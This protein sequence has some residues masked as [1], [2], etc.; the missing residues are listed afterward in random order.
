VRRAFPVREE[1]VEL[2]AVEAEAPFGLIADLPGSLQQMV[3]VERIEAAMYS[4][5][6]LEVGEGLAKLMTH[7]AK[8]RGQFFASFGDGGQEISILEEP[9]VE[10]ANYYKLEY[11]HFDRDG[12]RRGSGSAHIEDVDRVRV[13]YGHL[14]RR[15]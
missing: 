5:L 9:G 14:F 13:R 3:D 1:G 6:E 15:E 7:S 2:R 12:S 10:G 11:K 4:A 8:T